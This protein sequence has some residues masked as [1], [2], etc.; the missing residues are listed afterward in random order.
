[1]AHVVEF[2][3]TGLAGRHDTYSQVLNKDVNIFFGF[4]GSGKTSLLKILHSALSGNVAI[5]KDVPFES[6]TVKIYSID[7]D[8]VF[9]R[10]IQ[11]A[12]SDQR[13]KKVVGTI[14]SDTF[15]VERRSSSEQPNISWKTS[16]RPPK[17]FGGGWRHRYLPTSRLYLGKG[18]S[19]LYLFRS[20][21][22]LES[23]SEEDLDL[24]YAESLRDLWSSYSTEI[25]ASVRKAQEDGLASIVKAV[26]S[27]GEQ[28]ELVDEVD[29]VTAYHRVAAFL[30]RQGSP[31]VLGSLKEFEGL[32]ARSVPIRNVVR[33]INDVEAKI[34]RALAPR[35]QL[36]SLIQSMFIG[37]KRVLFTDT[38]VDVETDQHTPISLN[39]L[40]SGEKHILWLF[41]ETLLG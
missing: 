17:K 18:L 13:K 7:Y 9:T 25:L 8:K 35:E 14:H 36:K 38:S 28:E 26:L 19:Y 20:R 16:P 15:Y 33:D 27:L 3:V 39:L 34:E 29:P 2:S 23:L 10:T 11:K 21:L 40:S 30:T 5:L 4:N 37:S 6:A 22:D 41:I 31:N 12:S 32:Y 24:Y 1:M